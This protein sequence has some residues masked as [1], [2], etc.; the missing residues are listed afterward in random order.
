MSL[1]A[2][3]YNRDDL[4]KQLPIEMIVVS[5]WGLLGVEIFGS[6]NAEEAKIKRFKKAAR[7]KRG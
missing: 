1:M 2:A 6:G 4:H 7:R 3:I 5:I